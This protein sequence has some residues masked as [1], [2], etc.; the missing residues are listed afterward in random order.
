M[1]PIS[2][3]LLAFAV[4]LSLAAGVAGCDRRAQAC[5]TARR[6]LAHARGADGGGA[7]RLSGKAAEEAARDL[8]GIDPAIPEVGKAATGLRQALLGV[9]AAGRALE[10]AVEQVQSALGRPGSGAAAGPPIDVA[11]ETDAFGR[12]SAALLGPCIGGALSGVARA[13][14]RPGGQGDAGAPAA[15][16]PCDEIAQ[17]LDRIANP[18]ASTSLSAHALASAAALEGLSGL[19]SPGDG[20]CPSSRRADPPPGGGG[21]R[22]LRHGQRAHRANQAGRRGAQGARGRGRARR[23]GGRGDESD[24]PGALRRARGDAA[25]EVRPCPFAQPLRR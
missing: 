12:D 14:G 3:R 20:G 13:L 23:R 21:P 24:L 18:D 7:G 15:P 16:S 19:R 11:A 4:L 17:V 5:E 6:A 2:I 10:A 8:E 22:Q 1:T 25:P 9:A